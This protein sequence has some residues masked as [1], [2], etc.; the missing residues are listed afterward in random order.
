MYAISAD[1]HAAIADLCREYRVKELWLFGSAARDDFRPES[2]IDL[3]YVFEADAKVGLIG[4]FGLQ[5]K[6]AAL[7]G[8]KVDLVS[9]EGLK[10]AIR[11]GVLAD[12][13]RIYP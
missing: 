3:L 2:D 13:K 11:D 10:P 7:F 4:F 8:R 1:I 5:D 12:A 6:L 9:K